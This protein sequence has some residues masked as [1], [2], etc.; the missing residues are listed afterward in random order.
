MDF[1][2]RFNLVDPRLRRGS[3]RLK[4]ETKFQSLWARIPS[5]V[6]KIWP[7]GP[8]GRSANFKTNAGIRAPQPNFEGRESVLVSKATFWP[9]SGTKR[10]SWPKPI[11][12][13]VEDARNGQQ[14]LKI[15]SLSSRS[16]Y[17]SASLQSVFMAS[18]WPLLA[19]RLLATS[20]YS[21]KSLRLNSLK[22]Q[23]QCVY[24]FRLFHG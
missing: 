1:G 23:S 21:R 9:Q 5:L 2:F 14:S 4:S 11:V 6:F 12:N 16:R 18:L 7:T 19:L 8:A 3:T 24:W 10:L 15:R 22:I 17:R 20:V 13:L